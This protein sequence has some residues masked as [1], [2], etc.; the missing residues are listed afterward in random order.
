MSEFLIPL[1]DNN[2]SSQLNDSDVI[3][4]ATTSEDQVAS[5]DQMATTSEDQDMTITISNEDVCSVR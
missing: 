1:N 5:E 3:I 4:V 2:T